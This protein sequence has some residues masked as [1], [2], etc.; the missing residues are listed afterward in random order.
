MM[1]RGRRSRAVDPSLRRAA[2]FAALPA[3]GGVGP[4]EADPQRVA[5]QRLLE[6]LDPL[7]HAQ[8]QD[9]QDCQEERERG[10]LLLVG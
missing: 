4:G 6:L 1:P 3:H 10:K 8:V 9:D 2:V 5:G 7:V